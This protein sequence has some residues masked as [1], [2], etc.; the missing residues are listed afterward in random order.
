MRYYG[1]SCARGSCGFDRSMLDEPSRE[2]SPFPIQWSGVD[3]K[4]PW[5]LLQTSEIAAT[6]KKCAGSG[7]KVS[8]LARWLAHRRARPWPPRREQPTCEKL[9]L[10]NSCCYVRRAACFSPLTPRQSLDSLPRPPLFFSP[11][12]RLH[13]TDRLTDRPT[14]SSRSNDQRTVTTTTAASSS[15]TVHVHVHLSLV[16]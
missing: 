2:I 3:V 4:M 7:Q 11:L 15:S 5:Q 16:P 12:A 1:T 6:Q 8:V 10:N 13:Y 14:A 9:P